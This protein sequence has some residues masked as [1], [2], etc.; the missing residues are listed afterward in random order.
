MLCQDGAGGSEPRP[1]DTKSLTGPFHRMS[2]GQ[3]NCMLPIACDWI[4]QKSLGS[5]P[6]HIQ[7]SYLLLVKFMRKQT[8]SQIKLE[9]L[10]QAVKQKHTG[11]AGKLHWL[12]FL[13]VQN[14]VFQLQILSHAYSFGGRGFVSCPEALSRI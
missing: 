10:N 2:D 4:T 12:N 14:V 8:R 13:P 6:I 11:Q 7:S 3:P 5:L 1:R 9:H